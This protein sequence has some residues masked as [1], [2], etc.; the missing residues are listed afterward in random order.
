[1]Y[2]Y[3]QSDGKYYDKSLVRA[4]FGKLHN[5]QVCDVV[6]PKNI[7]WTEHIARM[8]ARNVHKILMGKVLETEHMEYQG[9]DGRIGVWKLTKGME[10]D[11]AG[12]IQCPR[13]CFYVSG[14]ETTGS[15]TR[16]LTGYSVVNYSI[17]CC[18]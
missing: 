6:T 17:K 16:R 2:S 9:G 7:R 15:N 3:L 1:L 12:W 13:I 14:V 10:F 5:E 11:N 18:R 8:E 4:E